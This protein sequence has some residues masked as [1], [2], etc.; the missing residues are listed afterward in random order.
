MFKK[1][2]LWKKA[3]LKHLFWVQDNKKLNFYMASS[4]KSFC[5]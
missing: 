2:N 5:A 1:A 4:K 3:A